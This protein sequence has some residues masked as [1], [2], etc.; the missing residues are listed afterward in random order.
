VKPN[1]V[2]LSLPRF[3]LVLLVISAWLPSCGGSVEDGSDDGET[4]VGGS[5]VAS[6][7]GS[8]NGTLSSAV[9]GV[10][11][12]G[13]A[14]WGGSSVIFTGG[15]GGVTGGNECFV[16]GTWYPL[17]A[18]ISGDSCSSCFCQSGGAIACA[19]AAPPMVACSYGGVVLNSGDVVP[20]LEGCGLCTCKAVTSL[21]SFSAQI[22]CE[23]LNC[24]GSCSYAGWTYL[25]GVTFSATD[26]CNSCQC[27]NGKVIC[28]E[29]SCGCSPSAETWRFYQMSDRSACAAADFACPTGT[30][31]FDNQCGCGCEQSV[32]CPET[33]QCASDTLSSLD[34]AAVD[35]MIP[36]VTTTRYCL[37]AKVCPIV[38]SYSLL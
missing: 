16:N 24:A 25:N 9:G 2:V 3:S 8:R 15:S 22:E 12:I 1:G 14:S 11:N 10:R 19:G 6:Y 28:T 5:T 38:R 4:G 34:T 23:A 27:V 36:T 35:V 13:G 17:G 30:V 26:G 21:C 33:H 37:D 32:D 18:V 31:R 20:S 29:A 7:G